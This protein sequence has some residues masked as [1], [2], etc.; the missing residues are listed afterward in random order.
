[1]ESV[2]ADPNIKKT[3]EEKEEEEDSLGQKETWTRHLRSIVLLGLIEAISFR[4]FESS[5]ML[6]VNN[7][8]DDRIGRGD[9][10]PRFLGYDRTGLRK[11]LPVG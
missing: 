8:I 10:L 4:S 9:I 5:K 3:K 11:F 6:H 1:M 2:F 7:V